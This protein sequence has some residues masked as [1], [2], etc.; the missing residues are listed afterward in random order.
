M[1]DGVAFT[2]LDPEPAERFTPLRRALGVT[3]M[4]INQ[5]T[6]RPGERGRIHAHARQEEV[7]LVLDGVLTLLVEGEPR[8]MGAGELVRVAPA[9]RRQLVNLGPGPVTVLALGAASPHDGRDGIASRDWDDP[10][11][12]PP[13]EVPLPDDLPPEALRTRLRVSPPSSP[14]GPGT[15]AGAGRR[16]RPSRGRR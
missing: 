1:D 10:A 5:I 7:F 11:P 16:V 3:T 15:P 6:L 9:V 8:D 12:G 2:R 13:Q 14:G 4:G